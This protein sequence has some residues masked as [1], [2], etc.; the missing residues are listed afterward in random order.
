MDSALRQLLRLSPH[1]PSLTDTPTAAAM[2]DPIQ[3]PASGR[4]AVSEVDLYGVRGRSMSAMSGSLRLTEAL[5]R[6]P[7]ASPA[8]FAT[9]LVRATVLG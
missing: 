4:A 2:A 9:P 5:T 1:S 3:R 7:S 6:D 8:S